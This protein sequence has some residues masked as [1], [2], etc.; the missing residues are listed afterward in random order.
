[1]QVLVRRIHIYAG[2]L[3]LAHL[4]LYGIAGLVATVQA[5]PERPRRT[6]S[7]RYV[8]F[9][10]PGAANDK[11]VARL[12]YDALHLPLTRP[13]PDWFLRRTVE[14]HLQL[15]FYNING[16][17][18]VIVLE[19]EQRLRIEEIRNSVWLFLADIHAA[20]P[21]D[22][23]APPLVRAWALWNEAAMWSL[24]AFCLSGAYLWLATRP[25]LAWAWA[26]LAS[27][28]AGFA[29]LWSVFR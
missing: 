4:M 9:I 1:M 11:E 29:A 6:E 2:L 27:G 8:P 15:D 5:S 17:Y 10:A 28:T 23:D 19:H 3:T 22:S 12:V 14:N 16:F 21:S 24:F 18:R 20:T 26:A 13:M 7:L 25:R